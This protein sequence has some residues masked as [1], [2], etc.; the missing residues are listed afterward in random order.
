MLIVGPF[1]WN[2]MR[3]I[4]AHTGDSFVVAYHFRFPQHTG[5]DQTSLSEPSPRIFQIL[6]TAGDVVVRVWK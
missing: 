6:E 1:F 2:E 5:R 3:D 4:G